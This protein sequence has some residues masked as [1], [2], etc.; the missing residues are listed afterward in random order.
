MKM[1]NKYQAGYERFVKLTA[2]YETYVRYSK[3]LNTFFDY[4]PEKSEPSDWSRH[5]MDDFRNYRRKAGVSATTVNYDLQIVRAFFNWMIDMEM[6]TYNPAAKVRRLKQTEPVRQSLTPDSQSELYA[7]CLN[8][9]ERLLVGLALSTGLRGKT[10]TQLEK[11]EFNF[12]MGM[13]VVPPEKMK[14]DRA[15]ELPIRASE[16]ALVAALP[17]GN[18][19]GDW[20][21][22]TDALSRRWT[23]ILKRIG[24]PLRGL[25]TAR[26][27]VA[28][29]LL[30]NGA[31]IRL[32]ADVL[33]HRKIETTMKYLTPA[34]RSQVSAAIATL[35][36]GA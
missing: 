14:T 18:L 17:E 29:T 2:S 23:L 1:I 26:R 13:L 16:L 20:A 36:T 15:M 28:T 33:G 8:D 11:K 21:K 25:R 4:F 22:T 7:A 19:W 35:P 32:V 10:L 34:T 6:A 12:E 5:D 27:S 30:R 31:D 3:S 24:S 9:K